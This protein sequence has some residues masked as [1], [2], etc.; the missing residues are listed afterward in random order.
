MDLITK[1][2]WLRCDTYFE[3]SV[4]ARLSNEPKHPRRN[5]LIAVNEQSKCLDLIF[6]N[7]QYILE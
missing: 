4:H 7:I 5:N 3:Q 2:L 6:I 1:N